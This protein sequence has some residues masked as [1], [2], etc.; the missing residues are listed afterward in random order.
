MKSTTRQD[1]DS[2]WLGTAGTLAECPRWDDRSRSL[3]WVD[4]DRGA[5]HSVAGDPRSVAQSH[6]RL[7]GAPLAGA[8]SWPAENDPGRLMIAV[9]LTLYSFET[10]G[11]MRPVAV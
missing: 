4:I 10:S 1:A 7:A 5:V 8:V 9:G 6:E 2:A 3:T 11:T